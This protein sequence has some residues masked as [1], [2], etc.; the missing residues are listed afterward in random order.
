VTKS[1]ARGI[2][3]FMVIDW[4]TSKTCTRLHS[5]KRSVLLFRDDDAI[6]SMLPSSRDDDKLMSRLL[7][8]GF[9]GLIHDES[10]MVVVLSFRDGLV[11]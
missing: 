3:R 10:M 11:R 2:G 8:V 7:T 6:M 9:C 5:M 1:V 4:A